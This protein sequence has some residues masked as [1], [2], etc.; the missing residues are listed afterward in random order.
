MDTRFVLYPNGDQQSIVIRLLVYIY[1]D[2]SNSVWSLLCDCRHIQAATV[3][4]EFDGIEGTSWVLSMPSL[5][6]GQY[7]IAETLVV[8]LSHA[9]SLSLVLYKNL[10]LFAWISS[11]PAT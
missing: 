6:I 5:G 2:S 8:P 11:A 3:Q 9:R 10:C 1:L 4:F 7:F